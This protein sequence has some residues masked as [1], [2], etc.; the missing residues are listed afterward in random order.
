MPAAVREDE[1][2]ADDEILD[3]ASHEH[4]TGFRLRGDTSADVDGEAA[5]RCSVELDLAGVD[6]DP[7]VEAE[8]ARVVANG[9]PTANGTGGAVEDG[10][11]TVAG[12]VDLA[13]ATRPS[14]DRTRWGGVAIRS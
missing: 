9:E 8:R 5:N 13:P 2:R 12:D 6:A 3:R 1:P 11:K 4:I 10:K 7:Y 14:K